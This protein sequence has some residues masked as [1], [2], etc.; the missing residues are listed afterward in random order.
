MIFGFEV[1]L[2]DPGIFQ[3]QDFV[4][5]GLDIFQMMAD[6]EDDLFGFQLLDEV[7][8]KFPVVFIQG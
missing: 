3:D 2:G 4:G 5:D 8:D 1:E 6:D 7:V